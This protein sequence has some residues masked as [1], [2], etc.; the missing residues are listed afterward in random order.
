MPTAPL[1]PKFGKILH[2]NVV[3][4][5][6]NAH[7]AI[8]KIRIFPCF[9]LYRSITYATSGSVIPSKILDPVIMIPVTATNIPKLA[10]PI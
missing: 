6:I 7:P 4:N 5:A 3:A 10:F 8:I 9:P 2:I 1:N